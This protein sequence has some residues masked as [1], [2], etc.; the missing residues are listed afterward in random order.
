MFLSSKLNMLARTRS[1]WTGQSK[2]LLIFLDNNLLN[3]SSRM[4]AK[5]NAVT[6]SIIQKLILEVHSKV[7][8]TTICLLEIQSSSTIDTNFVWGQE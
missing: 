5:S 6:L 1:R 3:M 7:K 4:A 2:S 8:S